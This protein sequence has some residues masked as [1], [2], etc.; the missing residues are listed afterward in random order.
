[1][2]KWRERKTT[3]SDPILAK[4]DMYVAGAFDFTAGYVKENRIIL[5]PGKGTKG[6][7]DLPWP[8]GIEFGDELRDYAAAQHKLLFG[9][10]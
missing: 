10:E 3:T 2:L 5:W 4:L 8:D 6:R 7:V 1:V 9:G